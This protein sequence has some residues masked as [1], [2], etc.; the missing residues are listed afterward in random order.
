MANEPEDIVE[1]VVGFLFDEN[2]NQ[3][4]LIHKQRPA[5]QKGFLNGVGGHLKEN[6]EPIVAMKRE[7][8]EEMGVRTSWR[9]FCQLGDRR[10]WTVHFFCAFDSEALDSAQTQTDEEIVRLPV[11]QAVLSTN[12]IPNLRWLIPMALNVRDPRERANGFIVTET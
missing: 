2:C 11:A 8:V 12:V 7:A 9:T 10:H 1:Y 5:W 4:A 6:E 3:M